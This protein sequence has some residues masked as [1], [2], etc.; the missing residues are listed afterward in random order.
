MILKRFGVV[1]IGGVVVLSACGSDAAAPERGT[2]AP[3]ATTSIWADITSEVACG[4]PVASIIPPGADP[5]AYEI[6]LRDR[7]T[8]ERA[9]VVVANGGGLEASMTD[10]LGVVAAEGTDVIEMTTQVDLILH[11]DA[12]DDDE[13]GHTSDDGHGH[14]AEGDPHIWQDPRRVAGALDLIDTALRAHDLETCTEAYRAELVSLDAEIDAMIATIPEP[15][16]VMVTSHDSL[17]YFAD[18][19]GITVVGTVIPSTNTMAQTNAADLAELA[20]LIE[21]FQVPAIFTERLESSNDADAL[22]NRLGVAIVPLVT[23]SLTDDAGSDTY[24]EMMRSNA[25]TIVEA[26]TP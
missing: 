19:Y 25:A 7:E 3:V 26:L 22:A 4:T 10:L 17:A 5:H 6:S 23:D 14:D 1:V 16:R 15:N 9:G 24:I 8:V 20:D 2:G 21:T 11:D 18:R 13:D 12:G